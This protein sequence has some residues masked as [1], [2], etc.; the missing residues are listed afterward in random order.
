MF[1][2]DDKTVVFIS[3][4][5]LV[6]LF[7][8]LNPTF[9]LEMHELLLFGSVPVTR[10]D[11]MLQILAGVA[12]MQPIRIVEKHLIFQPVKPANLNGLTVETSQL[13]QLQALQKQM[14]GDPYYLQLVGDLTAAHDTR[15]DVQVGK[16]E[17]GSNQVP[18]DE[19]EVSVEV[20]IESLVSQKDA[21][22]LQFRD[23]PEV[24]GRRPVNSRLMVDVD[25]TCENP[26][27]FMSALNYA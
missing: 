16:Q 13:Q 12:A 27:T 14:R 7:I 21:W 8:A 9:Y 11:Q 17:D 15:I 2:I 26:V 23:L 5:I 6:N 22:Q 19:E 25:I 3:F 18:H 1:L 24:A 20:P 10:H 4:E